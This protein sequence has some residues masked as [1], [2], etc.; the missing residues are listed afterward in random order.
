[1]ARS[2]TFS[3]LDTT[4]TAYFRSDRDIR[5]NSAPAAS[6]G[7]T[8]PGDGPDVKG[9]YVSAD[10]ANT[11]NVLVYVNG[12]LSGTLIP[13][14]TRDW[15]TIENDLTASG[16]RLEMKAASGTVAGTFGT[17]S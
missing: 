15:V 11:T 5:V 10:T 17:L 1:M 16:G 14:A 13:G 12:L 3:S 7:V 8:R 9:F 2:G 4:Q 6:S